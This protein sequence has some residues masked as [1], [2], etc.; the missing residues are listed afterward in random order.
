MIK[1]SKTTKRQDMNINRRRGC[2]CP[3]IKSGKPDKSKFQVIVVGAGPAGIT[4][5]YFLAKAGVEVLLVERGP[6]PGSKNVSGGAVY[7]LPTRELLDDFWK[8]APVERALVDQQYWLMT[9]TSSVRFG[10]KDLNFAKPPYNKFS[11]MRATFDRWYASKAVKAGVVLWTSCKAESLLFDQDKVAGVRVSGSHAG[12]IYADIVVLAQGANPLLAERAG[13][14]EKADAKNQS[15][16]I[17]QTFFLPEELI[18]ERFN[19]E[20]NQGAV[21]GLLGNNTADLI[22]TGSIYTYKEHLGINSGISVR[23][24][25]QKKVRLKELISRLNRHPVIEPVIKGG[26]LVEYSAHLIPE[27]GFNAVPQ[28]VFNGM[29][30]AGDAGSLVNGTHGFNLA[31]ISGKYAADTAIDALVKG[32]FAINTLK[33]YR[34]RLE[35]SMVLKDMRDNSEVPQLFTQ[36]PTLFA[37]YIGILNKVAGRV[38]TVYPISRRRKRTI[39]RKDI[40]SSV[41]AAKL[42]TDVFKTIKA[43]R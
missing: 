41:P 37:D 21:I 29:M 6:Y 22:G 40:L 17:K 32:D 34:D 7:T 2:Y 38:A 11:I 24:L 3:E 43:I 33:N 18:N 19:L 42:L 14:I 1:Y 20:G 27:G 28:L 15:L 26:K 16:Y 25:A 12:D 39:I 4:S 10:Y 36:N 30:I 23:T 13:L 8:E 35:N 9:D 31:I 5:A